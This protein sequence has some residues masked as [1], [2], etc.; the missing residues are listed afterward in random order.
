M[1]EGW[2]SLNPKT[3]PRSFRERDDVLAQPGGIGLE[4]AV[5]IE[6]AGVGEEVWVLVHEDRGHADG[7]LPRV[8][9]G[10]S[11]VSRDDGKSFFYFLCGGLLRTYASGDCPVLVLEVDVGGDALE[12]VGDSGGPSVDRG[13][14]LVGRLD[15]RIR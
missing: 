9:S 6:G 1:E 7:G 8:H 10:I 13:G 14:L 2:N 4:P 3:L 12:P 15:F 11:V 5:G